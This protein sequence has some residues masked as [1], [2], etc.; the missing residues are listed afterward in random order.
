MSAAT[1][2]YFAPVS[3]LLLGLAAVA[4]TT[5][6]CT[7]KA[8]F[9]TSDAESVT[10]GASEITFENYRDRKIVIVVPPGNHNPKLSWA[11]LNAPATSTSPANMPK[12]TLETFGH[13]N[14]DQLKAE[15][16]RRFNESMKNIAADTKT[17]NEIRNAGLKYGID[18]VLI[19]GN[20]IGEHVYNVPLQMK[21]QDFVMMKATWAGKWA[22]RFTSNGVSLVELLKD[23][24]FAKCDAKKTQSHADYWDCVS[25]VWEVSY[26]GRTLAAGTLSARTFENA[27]FKYTFFNPISSGYTYGIGQLDPVR[28]LMVAEKVNA[29]SGLRLLT[30]DDPVAIYEDIIDPR[31]SVHYVAANIVLSIEIYKKHAGFDISKNPGLLATLY[32]LGKERHFAALRYQ[33]TMA[34]LKSGAG[35]EIPVESYYGFFINE[36]EQVLRAFLNQGS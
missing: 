12:K 29:V 15:L 8:D 24:A 7:P 25:N 10:P 2:R 13:L 35:V 23:Q 34:T 6:G 14:T 32:N 11:T 36:K 9:F 27:S 30:I 33:Q 4:L 3:I 22:L 17:V 26:R 5:V 18:P 21:A 19:L 28:A 1:N 16:E 31:T 20:I